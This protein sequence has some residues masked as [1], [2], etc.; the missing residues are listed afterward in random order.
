MK[1]KNK[2]K[3]SAFINDAWM[4]LKFKL[5]I[6][7]SVFISIIIVLMLV[8]SDIQKDSELMEKTANKYETY[9][10][11][12]LLSKFTVE[13]LKDM[14]PDQL[15]LSVDMVIDEANNRVVNAPSLNDFVFPIKED[16]YVSTFKLTRKPKK[17]WSQEDID[18]FWIDIESLDIKHLDE[19]NFEYLKARLKEVR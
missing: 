16:N 12:L 15:K 9:I 3:L 19:N 4:D 8:V 13:E 6:I 2:K 7:G 10:D 14:G 11:Q 18:Q 1:K 17:K 5:I